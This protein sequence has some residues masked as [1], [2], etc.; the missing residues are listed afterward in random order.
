M[1]RHL[2]GQILGQM[3]RNALLPNYWIRSTAFFVVT[4][5]SAYENLTAQVKSTIVARDLR[6]QIP[7]QITGN[8]FVP[9]LSGAQLFGCS[10]SIQHAKSNFKNRLIMFL[11]VKGNSLPSE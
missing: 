3:T 5:D 4:F 6:G 1:A 7:G 8:V 11:V 10:H 2:R 9:E